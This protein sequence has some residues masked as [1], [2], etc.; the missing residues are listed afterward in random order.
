MNILLH[1]AKLS[2]LERPAI[3]LFLMPKRWLA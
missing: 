1:P 3:M 2:R